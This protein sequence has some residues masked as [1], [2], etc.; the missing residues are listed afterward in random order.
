MIVNNTIQ[1][2]IYF[3]YKDTKSLPLFQRKTTTGSHSIQN[4][5]FYCHLCNL[6]LAFNG[7]VHYSLTHLLH[8]NGNRHRNNDSLIKSLSHP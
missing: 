2:M 5:P 1:K 8:V 7:L 4:L 3:G 6:N